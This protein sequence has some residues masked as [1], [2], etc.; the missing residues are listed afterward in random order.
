MFESKRCH[1][2]YSF[3][4]FPFRFL[5][6]L[7]EKASA[8][9]IFCLLCKYIFSI[10]VFALWGFSCVQT[11]PIIDTLFRRCYNIPKIP[12]DPEPKIGEKETLL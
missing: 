2:F 11:L 3:T 1:K 7:P 10:F 12:E 6:K 9:A 4:N 8:A 5:T